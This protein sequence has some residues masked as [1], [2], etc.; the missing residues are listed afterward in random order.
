[1]TSYLVITKVNDSQMIN[2]KTSW[3]FIG[4]CNISESY[5]CVYMCIDFITILVNSEYFL[6]K[7]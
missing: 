1:M 6:K 4:V 2:Q 3:L 5:I 7:D